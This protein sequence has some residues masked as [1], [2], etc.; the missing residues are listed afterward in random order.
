VATT[1]YSCDYCRATIDTSSDLPLI[2][3]VHR[4]V[5]DDE[6]ADDTFVSGESRWFRYCSQAHLAQ[7]MAR[8]PLPPVDLETHG[9]GKG[10]A[11]AVAGALVLVVLAGFGATDLVRHL[12]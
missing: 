10:L 11:W 1:S 9:A 5:D 7:H 6:W 8:A 12:V 3:G 4:R 2:V